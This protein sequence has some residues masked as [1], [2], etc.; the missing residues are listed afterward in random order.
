VFVVVIIG[1]IVTFNETPNACV[2]PAQYM[3][4]TEERADGRTLSAK[5]LKNLDFKLVW[6]GLTRTHSG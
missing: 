3:K 1:V 6:S 4:I 5:M 2:L